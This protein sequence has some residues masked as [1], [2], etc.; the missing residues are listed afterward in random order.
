MGSDH[1]YQL[2]PPNKLAE[3]PQWLIRQVSDYSSRSDVGFSET[4]YGRFRFAAATSGHAAKLPL[5]RDRGMMANVGNGRR[6]DGQVE[7]TA[8]S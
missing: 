4:S 8:G 7:L 6:L 2:A 5:T 3:A 1:E